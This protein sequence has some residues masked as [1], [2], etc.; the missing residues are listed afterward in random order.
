MRS[1][2]QQQLPLVEALVLV[3]PSIE[4]SLQRG[5]LLLFFEYTTDSEWVYHM[6]S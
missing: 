4:A 6:P 2:R 1:Y 3:L 5:N